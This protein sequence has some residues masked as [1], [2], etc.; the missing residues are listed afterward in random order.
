[1]E[2]LDRNGV[3][4]AQTVNLDCLDLRAMGSVC[5]SHVISCRK[6]AHI[7][8]MIGVLFILLDVHAIVIKLISGRSIDFF[9]MAF[10]TGKITLTSF[11]SSSLMPTQ[12]W[13]CW[14][15]VDPKA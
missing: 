15:Q 14:L 11:L 5:H 9:A 13:Y 8:D 3:F 7:F 2:Y 10:P 6:H 4:P 1:M 12:L